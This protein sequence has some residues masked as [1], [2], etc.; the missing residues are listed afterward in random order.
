VCVC[1]TLSHS[2]GVAQEKLDSVAGAPL[3]HSLGVAQEVVPEPP[4]HSRQAG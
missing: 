3:S 4:V 1:A 2:S